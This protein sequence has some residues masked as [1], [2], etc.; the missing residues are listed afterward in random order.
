M[1]YLFFILCSVWV[2]PLHAQTP[3][4]AWAKSFTGSAD[5]HS[6]AIASDAN[7]NIYTT[8]DFQG[9]VDFD[10]G[11]GVFNLTSA[12]NEDIFISKCDASGNFIWA[13][14]IGGT[15]PDIGNS[16]SIDPNGD[17]VVTGTYQSTVDFDPGTGIYNYTAP[18]PDYMFLLKLNNTGNFIWA[19]SFGTGVTQGFAVKTD[20][21]GNIYA[22]GDFE[23]AVD[24]D[25]GVGTFIVS[26][27]ISTR[28]IFVLKLSSAGNLI[29]VKSMGAGNPEYGRALAFDTSGNVIVSGEFAGIVDFDPGPAIY[30]MQTSNNALY[31]LK[32]DQN[33]N[34]IWAKCT[35]GGVTYSFAI[36]V[37]ANNNVYST[38]TYQFTVD[39]DPGTSTNNVT[40]FSSYYNPYIL[41]LDGAGNFVW[42]KTFYSSYWPKGSGIAV[43]PSGD[44]YTVG[45][46]RGTVDFDPG[47]G[48][49]NL[50]SPTNDF[51]MFIVK[52]NGA[53]NFIWARNTGGIASAKAIM[54]NNLYDIYTTG[55]FL[56]TVDFNPEAAVNNLVSGGLGNVFIQKLYQSPCIQPTVP[57]ISSSGNS[58]CNGQSLNLSISS[59]SLNSAAYWKWYSGSCNGAA[60]GTGN[61]ITVNPTL[62]TTYYVRGE[63][64][65]VSTSTCASVPV[66]VYSL[67]SVTATSATT[68]EGIP[69]TLN[70]SPSGGIFSVPN[71][72]T[73]PS[74]SFT[75]TFTDGNGC[76]NTSSPATIT[77]H[78][79]PSLSLSITP[80]DTV[81]YQTP[82][83]LTA[84]G[85][86]SYV[87]TGAVQNPLNGV[88]FTPSASAVYTVQA[89]N[90]AGCTATTSTTI[91]VLNEIPQVV[92]DS[93]CGAGTITVQGVGSG[94]I[95]W[96]I[97]S[98]GGSI[99]G[100]GNTF[101]TFLN[102]S[103]TFY[104]ENVFVKNIT[105][106]G[107]TVGPS[108]IT[109]GSSTL[110][111]SNQYTL[112]NVLQPCVLQSVIVYPGAAGTVILEQ[113]D[114]T[115]TQILNTGSMTVTA[116]QIGTAVTMSLNWN[117][118]PGNGYRVYRNAA[119]V[120]LYRNATGGTYPYTHSAVVIT[121]NSVS[122][123]NYWWAYQWQLLIPQTH[124]CSSERMPV[125]AVVHSLPLV[126]ASPVNGCAGST[127]VLNGSPAGGQF[128]IPNPYI[129]PST[130]Y[131][132]SYT[133]SNGCSASATSTISIDTCVQNFT[134]KCF[135]EGYYHGMQSMQP[136]LLNQG[137]STDST[138][139]DLMVVEL[140]QSNAPYTLVKSVPVFLKVNG[141]I[142][143]STELPQG[144]YYL[145]LKHRNSITTWSAEP[146]SMNGTP[147]VYDFT[148]AATKAYG[149]NMK[150][151]E[152]GVWA[153]YSG[154][155]NLD[156][157]VDLLDLSLLETAIDQFEAGY[158]S[159]DINGDG[160]DDL[161]DY[162]VVDQNRVE[163]I[164]VT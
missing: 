118:T 71:P 53:G 75:Y 74:A 47:T 2:N 154:D 115:G 23:G 139:T 82:V 25:P 9:T 35:S 40:N 160:N 144:T 112:F 39:F 105:Q 131:S 155:I 138:L 162:P 59:G 87:W 159:T 151:V 80:D 141:F 55:R 8:G 119:S 73:G 24:F 113:R 152:N 94:T 123:N 133:D 149:M 61:S 42:V 127:V 129:G 20:P 101:Q 147:L 124:Y 58:I 3:T 41:K 99:T 125:Y 1:K 6:N 76:S 43:D 120:A 54:V 104:A 85:A 56:G 60:V 98:G 153:F 29:W 26:S 51:D 142:Q 109:I 114:A 136:V 84:S 62:S 164:A 116:A 148:Y 30:N 90:A 27:Y 96:Y 77:I 68:C 157:N 88:S 31:I 100:T 13:K 143:F 10:P 48:T 65:C 12:G 18:G 79:N 37:D 140:H 108:G 102:T 78:A 21:N 15:N 128:S 52:L 117:L 156:E 106:L 81:C 17:V 110:S 72:Y 93:I 69:L 57:Q 137:F 50:S 158:I 64:G 135:L 49:Y 11:A 97:Q 161:L 86:T 7:G 122:P 163:F 45:E 22:T 92:S 146:L 107:G 33:G 130:I 67:P 19:R 63:G 103:Q 111:T 16:I 5:C 83:T 38:G 150:E 66:N 89:T 46:F 32:L 34:F 121:G 44:V 145:V 91:V 95:N 4:F 28:D 134:L 70:G 126:T 14:R 36:T 132:Y